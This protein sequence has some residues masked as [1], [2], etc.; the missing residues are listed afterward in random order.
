MHTQSDVLATTGHGRVTVAR[1]VEPGGGD[2]VPLTA[3]RAPLGTAP[4]VH[5]NCRPIPA[6][7]GETLHPRAV[8]PVTHTAW[9]VSGT[10][11]FELVSP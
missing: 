2:R 3:P 11:G 8:V 10:R 4:R 1:D 7:P 9:V 5:F 6:L